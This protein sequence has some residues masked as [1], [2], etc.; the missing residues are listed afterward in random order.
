[1]FGDTLYESVTLHNTRCTYGRAMKQTKRVIE[2]L[3][4]LAVT[5]SFAGALC[6]AASQP[7][8]A[9]DNAARGLGLARQWCSSCHTV[10]PQQ[11]TDSDKAPTFTE[12]AQRHDEKWIKAWLT[13]PHPPMQGITLSH[14]Q[15]DDLT[16]YIKSLS[17]P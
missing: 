8:L 17:K 1:M 4:A 10:E 6:L 7:A 5:T 9:A 2:H 13:N 12:I 11:V 14:T 3:T 16:A 15:I